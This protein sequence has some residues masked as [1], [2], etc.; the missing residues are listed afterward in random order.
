MARISET[1]A[2]ADL[3]GGRNGS[4][5]SNHL[6]ASGGAPPNR[7]LR[8]SPARRA[9][10]TAEAHLNRPQGCPYGGVR[11]TS[12]RREPDLCGSRPWLRGLA[13]RSNFG[14]AVGV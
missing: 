11:L 1:A 7:T 5:R 14:W 2:P 3:F 6:K 4:P 8:R 9:G 13:F 12:Q 10:W